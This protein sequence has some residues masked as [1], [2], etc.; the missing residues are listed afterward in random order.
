MHHLPSGSSNDPTRTD[1][2]AAAGADGEIRFYRP[3]PN[4]GNKLT[5]DCS[6]NGSSQGQYFVDLNDPSTFARESLSDLAAAVTVRGKTSALTGNLSAL[7]PIDLLQ[8]G[9]PPPP[10]SGT[11]PELYNQ[12]MQSVSR[13]GTR[14]Q[15]APVLALGLKGAGQSE[16]HCNGA[17]TG[18]MQAAVGFSRLNPL[19]RQFRGLE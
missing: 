16:G 10:N 1:I 7:S 5:L 12:W 19:S 3:P 4:W 13:P 9:Y 14:Y 2:T 17:W 15:L 6:L 11:Q 18:F 8:Q